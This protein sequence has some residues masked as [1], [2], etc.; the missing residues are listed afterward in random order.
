LGYRARCSFIVSRDHHDVDPQVFEALHGLVGLGT[1]RIRQSDQSQQAIGRAHADDRLG[2]AS[3]SEPIGVEEL[4]SAHSIERAVELGL[5]AL[6]RQRRELLGIGE[7]LPRRALLIRAHDRLG[8]GVL[9]LALQRRGNAQHFC[10]RYAVRRDDICH[11]E[12]ARRQRARL[13]EDDSLYL[14]K[15]F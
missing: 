4:E 10:R 9:T 1:D 12:L 13:V 14:P 6:A 8:D 15:L 3:K 11:G 2:L 7:R 5:D